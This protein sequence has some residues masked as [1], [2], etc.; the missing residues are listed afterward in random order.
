MQNYGQPVYDRPGSTTSF[1]GQQ[2]P[3]VPPYQQQQQW[4]QQPPQQQQ[5]SAPGYNPSTYDAMPG[6]YG[7]GNQVKYNRHKRD[8]R[9]ADRRH[10]IHRVLSHQTLTPSSHTATSLLHLHLNRTGSQPRYSNRT[11]T[12]LSMGKMHRAPRTGS[13]HSKET[14]ASLRKHSKVAT[15]STTMLHLHHL[16][17]H[18]PV[19]TSLHH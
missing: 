8:V 15:L 9:Y 6:G 5:P 3:P 12:T 4:G 17:L 10:S 14:Q 11:S 16:L 1:A 18:R 19:H 13:S 7:Q 2:P